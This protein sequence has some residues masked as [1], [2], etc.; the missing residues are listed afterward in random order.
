MSD[1]GRCDNIASREPTDIERAR[2]FGEIR[3]FAAG[4]ALAAIGQVGVGLA[5][6][7]RGQ[8]DVYRYDA[9][10]ERQHL[11]KFGP[12]AF[13][14]ELAQL[15]GRHSFGDGTLCASSRCKLLVHPTQIENSLHL[16][17][18]VI[19]RHHLVEVNE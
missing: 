9:H 10:G 11:S 16:S 1:R 8:V 14:G 2:R 15:A 13:V 6:I 7:L 4:D 5:I 3:R 12:G 19:W 17:D 18:K